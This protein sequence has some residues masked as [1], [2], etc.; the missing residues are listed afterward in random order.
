MVPQSLP[1]FHAWGH[2]LDLLPELIRAAFAGKMDTL[3]SSPFVSLREVGGSIPLYVPASVRNGDI[4]V[5]ALK[6]PGST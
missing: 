4:S 6:R 3:I 5:R 2:C 1:T